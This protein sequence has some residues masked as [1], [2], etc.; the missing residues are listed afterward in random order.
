VKGRTSADLTIPWKICS[1]DSWQDDALLY[2]ALPMELP[3]MA[4]RTAL[5]LQSSEACSAI[6][7]SIDTPSLFGQN[8]LMHG[9]YSEGNKSLI[10]L[11][12][13]VTLTTEFTSLKLGT[14]FDNSKGGSFLLLDGKENLKVFYHLVVL[15]ET[16][17]VCIRFNLQSLMWVL[18]KL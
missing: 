12:P 14:R 4:Q 18:T 1:R 13:D 17:I 7:E 16:Y 2:A 11:P 8:R 6:M 15:H 3:L 5:R 10:S 9:P